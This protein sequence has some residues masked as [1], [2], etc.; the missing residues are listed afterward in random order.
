MLLIGL[1]AVLILLLSACSP[2]AATQPPLETEAPAVTAQPPL[3][4]ETHASPGTPAG[5]AVG[6]SLDSLDELVAALEAA[7][8]EVTVGDPVQDP[9]FTGRA[10]FL[11][12]N[13]QDLQV[14]EFTDAAARETAAAAIQANGY[15]IGNMA[16]DWITTP[17]FFAKDSLIVLYVGTDGATLDLL[18]GL[19][20]APLTG[21]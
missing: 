2:A 9:I 3:E 11:R 15:I 4:T 21:N 6:P 13:G 14:Y 12:L 18:T 19:L 20:G 5:A 8:G 10:V 7:G 17:Y 16:I 1:A